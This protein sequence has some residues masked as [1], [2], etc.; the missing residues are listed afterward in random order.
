[1]GLRST[2]RN[3]N[4]TERK[5]LGMKTSFLKSNDSDLKKS[6][7]LPLLNTMSGNIKY[8]TYKVDRI[9]ILLSRLSQ[10]KSSEDFYNKDEEPSEEVEN[11]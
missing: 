9:I 4:I 3:L 10:T 5:S 7:I 8:I 11:L 6:D 2:K 1:M